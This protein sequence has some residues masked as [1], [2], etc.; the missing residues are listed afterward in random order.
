LLEELVIKVPAPFLGTPDV[1]L[2]L[3]HI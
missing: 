3:I 1:G 2:S